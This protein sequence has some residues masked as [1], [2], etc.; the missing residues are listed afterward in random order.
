MN[1]GIAYVEYALAEDA[2]LAQKS[3]TGACILGRI[4]RVNAVPVAITRAPLLITNT[5]EDIDLI[6]A[7]ENSLKRECARGLE[8][9]AKANAISSEPA[10]A[11]QEPVEADDEQLGSDYAQQLNIPIEKSPEFAAETTSNSLLVNEAGTLHSECVEEY[12]ED[13]KQSLLSA[14]FTGNEDMPIMTA[15]NSHPKYVEPQMTTEDAVEP[16]MDVSAEVTGQLDTTNEPHL[17]CGK[18]EVKTSESSPG[19]MDKEVCDSENHQG[20]VA[21]KQIIKEEDHTNLPMTATAG[22]PVV[23][24]HPMINIKESCESLNAKDNKTTV[25]KVCKPHEEDLTTTTGPTATVV[26]DL[27]KIGEGACKGF[28]SKESTSQEYKSQEYKNGEELAESV[29][30]SA[31]GIW[32]RKARRR[33]QRKQRGF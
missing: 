19:Y 13:V 14:E 27:P 12:T 7:F 23:P 25:N 17:E 2:Y 30:K 28:W 4:I 5:K 11:E 18:D 29:K 3:M 24:D 22:L 8:R 1:Q 21:T 31:G 6:M 32:T 15:G 33:A 26:I 10:N 9:Y 20:E 16:S